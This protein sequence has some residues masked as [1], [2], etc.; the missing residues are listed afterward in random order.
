MKKTVEIEYVGIEDLQ[1]IIDD[2]YWLIKEG[3][4][5]SFE[6]SSISDYTRVCVRIMLGG[7]SFEKEYD[8]S[9]SFDMS[10]DKDDVEKMNQCKHILK[11][12]LGE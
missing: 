11:N 5:A 9:F 2:C 3:N 12:L 8:Y 6:M 10:D 1:V 4:Y 7:W